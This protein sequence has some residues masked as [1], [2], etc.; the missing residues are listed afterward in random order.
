M[1]PDSINFKTPVRKWAE[2]LSPK[3]PVAGPG[4]QSP[5]D[6][7]FLKRLPVYILIDTSGSMRGVPIEAVKSSLR[8]LF[9]TLRKIPVVSKLIHLSIITF[10]RTAKTLLPLSKLSGLKSLDFPP[11]E[12]SPTN[13]GEAL[14]LMCQKYNQEVNLSDPKGYDC[15]PMAIVITDGSPSDTELFNKMCDT[16]ATPAFRFH[17]ILACAAGPKGKP[18]PL[19]KFSTDVVTMDTMD[20]GNFNSFWQ[21][22]TDQI[23]DYGR[24]LKLIEKPPEELPP[25]PPHELK[26]VYS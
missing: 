8:N 3:P 16:L 26:F 19:K 21:W 13:L 18:E 6:P 20:A 9:S 25:L 7:K 11:L 10:D 4:A 15:P 5:K 2:E 24:E 14:E 23:T 12:S 17:K 22:V 1:K